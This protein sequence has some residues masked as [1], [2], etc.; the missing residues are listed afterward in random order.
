M[1]NSRLGRFNAKLLN[2][3]IATA[4]PELFEIKNGER[5][6]LFTLDYDE[7]TLTLTT[8]NDVDVEKFEAIFT[9]HDPDRL[10][11][12]QRREQE[13]PARKASLD[14]KLKALGLTADELKFLSEY[15]REEGQKS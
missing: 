5:F 6:A 8:R 14:A 4:S 12:H 7:Q 13:A 9:A 3:E 15:A 10:S 2:E 11:R 1:V